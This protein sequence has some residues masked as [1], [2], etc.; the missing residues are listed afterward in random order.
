VWLE[1]LGI[2]DETHKRYLLPKTVQN[3]VFAQPKIMENFHVQ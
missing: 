3:I 2:V 1:E